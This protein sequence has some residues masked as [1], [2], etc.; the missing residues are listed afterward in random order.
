MVKVHQLSLN[1]FFFLVKAIVLIE[2]EVVF[3]LML[4]ALHNITLTSLSV[5]YFKKQAE[6][7]NS[8]L[9]VVRFQLH[10]VLWVSW[11]I[12]LGHT[13]P[14]SLTMIWSRQR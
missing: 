12:S 5:N 1:Q 13:L 3:T 9:F 8:C 2:T 4:C 11:L 14:S 10:T 6:N 7:S